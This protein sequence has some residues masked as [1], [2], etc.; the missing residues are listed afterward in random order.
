MILRTTTTKQQLIQ[1]FRSAPKPQTWRKKYHSFL[2]VNKSLTSTNS[3]PVHPATIHFPIAFLSLAWGIDILTYLSPQLPR[4]ITSNLAVSTDL[5]RASYYLLS[6]GLI[7]AV[8][9]LASGIQQMVLYTNKS[10]LKDAQGNMRTKSKALLAHAAI[11]DV[12]MAVATYIWWQRRSAAANTISGKLGM[13]TA[14]T[15][16]AAYAPENWQVGAEAAIMALMFLSANIGGNLTYLF[17]MGLAMGGSG[18]GKKG[19]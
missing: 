15:A 18:S 14:S 17:G 8:P 3:K 7:T 19:Q 9:A 12:V 4:S 13:G 2:H 5:T 6:M 11:N 1:A 10:G 16:A